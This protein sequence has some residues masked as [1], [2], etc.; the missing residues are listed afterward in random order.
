MNPKCPIHTFPIATRDQTE[1]ALCKVFPLAVNH[2]LEE[3][4]P[5]FERVFEDDP[6]C[7]RFIERLPQVGMLETA[8]AEKILRAAQ[9]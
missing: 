9:K 3:A 2:S 1:I 7:A 8:L 5:L 4:M 6:N